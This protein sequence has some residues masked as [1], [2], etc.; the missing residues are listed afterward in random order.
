VE[1][2]SDF[3]F[4][5]PKKYTGFLKQN[6]PT[7]SNNAFIPNDEEERENNMDANCNYASSSQQEDN[8]ISQ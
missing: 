4:P 3:T 2:Y 5:N 8:A 7:L 1:T 6:K